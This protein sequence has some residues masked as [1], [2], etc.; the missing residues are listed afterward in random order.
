MAV[1]TLDPTTG[2]ITGKQAGSDFP[3][4]GQTP[5]GLALHASGTRLYVANQNT[6]D[7]TVFTIGANGDVTGQQTGSP[8]SGAGVS[9][10]GVALNPAPG[11]RR[12]YVAAENHGPNGGV[13]TFPLGANGDITGAG[14][15][16]HAASAFV[17]LYVA[18][19][20]QGKRLYLTDQNSHVVVLTLDA[21]GDITGE[22]P[23]SP[24]TGGI[25]LH[26][27]VNAAGTR[28]YVTDAG[29]NRIFVYPLSSSTGAV[30]GA[31]VPVNLG[32]VLGG[33][34]VLALN[35]EQTR[36]YVSI[37]SSPGQVAVLMLDSSGDVTGPAPSL[38]TSPVPTGGDGAWGL[39]VR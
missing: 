22:A 24:L 36:L 26:V 39:E 16:F 21:N 27:L 31:G 9:Y 32:G 10:F 8:V 18:V 25:P 6:H 15:L 13:V 2:A 3:T 11:V 7:V 14:T 4:G 30:T 19:H 5:I 37:R 28:L 12:L 38:P 20:P 29:A 34:T 33:A 17:P 35:P 1:Y 23:E